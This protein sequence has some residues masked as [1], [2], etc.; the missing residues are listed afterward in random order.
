MHLCSEFQILSWTSE[1][2]NIF[3]YVYMSYD[4][5]IALS[6]H[7]LGNIYLIAFVGTGQRSIRAIQISMMVLLIKVVSNVN[8]KTSTILVRRLILDSWLGPWSFLINCFHLK[9]KSLFDH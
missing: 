1:Y 9:F 7:G 4:V 8:L 2:L 5:K 3:D 6:D